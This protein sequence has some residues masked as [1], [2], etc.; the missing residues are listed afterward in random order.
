[1][2]LVGANGN[3]RFYI[4]DEYLNERF[5]VTT[6]V[7][8]GPVLHLFS[9]TN[10]TSGTSAWGQGLYI[11]SQNNEENG[12]AFGDGGFSVEVGAQIN[13]Y[14]TN[15]GVNGQG[16]LKFKTSNS[17][18]GAQTRITLDQNGVMYFDG[19]DPAAEKGCI[20]FDETTDK[21]QYS[22]DCSTYSDIGSASP[23]GSD[24][25]IQYNSNGSLWASSSFTYSSKG[26][27]GLISGTSSIFVGQGAGIND[28][29][30][31]NYNVALGRSALGA[32][33]SGPFNTGIGANAL[34]STSTGQNNTAVGTLSLA[35]NTTGDDNTAIGRNAMRYNTEADGNTAVG[36][37]ALVNFATTNTGFTY[38]TAIGYD[39]LKGVSSSTDGERNTA[40]GALAGDS[41]TTGDDNI[42]IGYNADLPTPTTNEYL[43]IGNLLYG[44]I[45][46]TSTD[47][48]IGAAKYCDETL[49][50]CFTT[51]D[52]GNAT[53]AGSDREIQ[54]NSGNSLGAATNFVYTSAGDFIVGSHQLDDTGTGSEDYRMFFDRSKGAF[55]AGHVTGAE[56]DDINV[57]LYSI[58]MGQS[59]KASGVGSFAAGGTQVPGVLAGPVASGDYST[60]IGS[61]DLTASGDYSIAIGT[62]MTTNGANSVAIGSTLSSSQAN[63]VAI[64][65]NIQVSG[66]QS[67]GL[68]NYVNISG[69]RSAAL[70][71][72]GVSGTR[73]IVSG[74]YSY[75]IF[76]GTQS[77]V[78][79]TPNY[80]MGLFGG[81]MV[82]DPNVPAT[83]LVA[84]VALDV[85]GAVKVDYDATACSSTIQGAIRYDSGGSQF[86]LC[87]GASWK[88]IATSSGGSKWT[89]GTGDD[90]YY[91]SGS[92]QVGI[93]L[94][95][96]TAALHVVGNDASV[97]D[98]P[99]AFYVLG[100]SGTSNGDGGRVYMKAGP[101]A[102]TG[103]GGRFVILGGNPAASTGTGGEV[104]IRGGENTSIAG[105]K[106]GNV[107]IEAG[108]SRTAP[109]GTTSIYGGGYTT[110]PTNTRSYL[111]LSGS[112]ATTSGGV[113]LSA[114]GITGTT[115]NSGNLTIK[116]QDTTLTSRNT[117]DISITAGD[118]SGGSSTGGTIT[119]TAG[120]TNNVAAAD[121]TLNPGSSTSSSDGNV[122][123][124]PTHGYVG[125][126]MTGPS[127]E[128]DVTGDIEYTGTITDVSDRR[129]KTD[130]TPLDRAAMAERL[131][132]IDT[133]S[134]RMK[135]DEKGQIEFGVMAQELERLFP[136]L[137]RTANDKMG[138]KSV[139]YVGLIAPM[140]EATK[141]LKAENDMLRAEL[142]DVRR[143]IAG[144]KAYTGYGISKAEMSLLMLFGLLLGGLGML[145]ITRR[146]A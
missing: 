85:T 28:D 133:Y 121:I 128:L 100:G 43:N 57:G 109:G 78:D 38:N 106:G 44:D 71:L 108:D 42:L 129:L 25:Q 83:N 115:T 94:T 90:I 51:G 54:F 13:F 67:I 112:W 79:F 52:V 137:V 141:T 86:D 138:T 139:N 24:T 114:G 16:G 60:A 120:D 40:L 32:I 19:N 49:T 75:G 37:A 63:A 82:I 48:K 145:V 136:E 117:G 10:K 9:P 1:M 58:A 126:G 107:L 130:I 103:T 97:D 36:K 65:S 113:I 123:L 99:D 29:G 15:G 143:D 39:S 69:L 66:V 59:S 50:T 2:R 118:A 53:A 56:W 101:A 47:P 35:T 131:M 64:G 96:P 18:S 55:R 98:A 61:T 72:K 30:T 92:P 41:I 132:Q 73:P 105:T 111:T 91:N 45:G 6:D 8:G 135:D 31:D 22:H 134:F 17:T 142:D 89:S 124:A 125:I 14:D 7:A 62:G 12:I 68:G 80:T 110:S 11:Q 5:R 140:I 104:Y 81:R 33:T 84:D 26:H 3:P 144:L 23:Y 93:G 127:V 46:T 87:D 146:K 20:Q 21:L 70:G 122:I 34:T 4:T 116:T 95:T 88:T 119:L 102:G 27:L 77:G 74:D 76:M